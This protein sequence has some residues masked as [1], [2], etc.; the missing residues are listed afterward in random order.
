MGDV[1]LALNLPEESFQKVYSIPKPEKDR[2][3]VFLCLAGVRSAKAMNIAHTLGYS[4]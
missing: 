4:K 2:D 1:E 3:V